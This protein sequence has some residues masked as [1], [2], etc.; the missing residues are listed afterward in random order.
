[1]SG[2]HLVVGLAAIVFGVLFAVI[3]KSPLKKPP[4]IPETMMTD[5]GPMMLVAAGRFLYAEDKRETIVP[6][7]YVDRTEVTN[8]AYAQFCKAKGHP[9]PQGFPG[10]KA[11][12][13][14]V[15]VTFTDANA[16]AK[17]S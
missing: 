3:W 16:F 6:A 9:L 17:W 12:D 14:V 8:Q 13:P 1:M 5:S 10:D 15:N 2:K 4:L 11:G 7:F